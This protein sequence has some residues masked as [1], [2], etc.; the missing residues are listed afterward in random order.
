MTV[1]HPV[2]ANADA[3]L[4]APLGRAAREREAAALAG[5]PVTFVVEAAGPAFD[6]REAALEAYAGRVEDPRPGRAGVAAEDRFC[7]LREML[8]DRPAPPLRPTKEEGRRWP[9]PA[10][11][12]TTVWRLSVAY[13]KLARAAAAAATGPELE[14]ARRLRR[15]KR[16][17]AALDAA[18]LRR[19]A[20][21]PLRPVRP[22][23]PLDLG[24]FE[25]RLPENPSI[26][27]PDE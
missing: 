11:R 3:A 1:L 2:A 14:Q 25:V 18:A 16:E 17:M 12:P 20:G 9:A 10:E 22:Q 8:V 4:N 21:Q 23:Q 7:D 13:W 27:M 24:L 26:V 6:T 19:L 5:E 15:T